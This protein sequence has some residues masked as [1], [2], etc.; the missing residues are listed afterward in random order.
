MITGALFA[1]V[2]VSDFDHHVLLDSLISEEFLL[3]PALFS[4]AGFGFLIW[5]FATYLA[6]PRLCFSPLIPPP[7]S[8][9]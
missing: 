7:I 3:L 4:I 2:P 1:L 9:T 8:R 6:P 5:F